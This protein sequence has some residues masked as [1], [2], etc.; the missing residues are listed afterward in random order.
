MEKRD[1]TKSLRRLMLILSKL[2]NDD[3]PN[4]KELAEEFQVTVRTIQKDIRNNLQ[5][6]PIIKDYDGR[7]M[8]HEGFS[9]N[10]TVLDNDEMMFLKIALSQFNDVSNID[11]IKER[12]FQKISMKNFYNPYYV[13]QDDIEDL[14]IDS[15]F[16]ERLEK[17]IKNDEIIEMNLP[18]KTVEV[19]A[20]KIANFDGFWYLFAKDLTDDKVKTFKLSEIKKIRPMDKYYR[21]SSQTI[22]NILDKAHSAFYTD[23]S[24]FKVVVKVYKEVAIYFKSKDFLESQEIIE[25]YEDGSLKV[26]FE[27]S[28]DEDIDN[29]I[30]AWLPHVEVL[31]PARFRERILDELENYLKKSKTKCS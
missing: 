16:I 11:K 25:E 17:Y 22:E 27:V 31:E 30:K 19:E 12:I 18:T 5:E 26:S 7:F 9:L 13:K 8:F 23:G 15:L 24:S 28:H 29:I 4:T 14:D 10:R 20:Y 3:R 1:Y 2:S 21:V 6:F